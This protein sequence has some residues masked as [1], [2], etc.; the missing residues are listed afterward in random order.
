MSA[1][2]KM[3]ASM[4]G[5]TP[6]KMQEMTQQFEGGFEFFTSAIL[7]IKN[8]QDLILHQQA[9]IL[10]RLENGR[11]NDSGNGPVKLIGSG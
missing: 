4:L 3:I 6:E 7:E 2:E 9:L 10:E 8:K 1:M 5:I 11:N